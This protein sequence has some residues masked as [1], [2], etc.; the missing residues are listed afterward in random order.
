LPARG[1]SILDTMTTG[2]TDPILLVASIRPPFLR[3]M[4][5][6]VIL[7]P[8]AGSVNSKKKEAL[9]QEIIQIFQKLN[10]EAEVRYVHPPE[11]PLFKVVVTHHPFLPPEDEPSATLVG[12]AELALE[13]L[14]QCG[15]DLLL[16]G[17][18]HKHY[19][20]DVRAHYKR[21]KRSILVVQAGTAVSKRLRGEKNS[22]NRIRVEPPHISIDR[23]TRDGDRFQHNM[24][25]R[26]K[27]TNE[28]WLPEESPN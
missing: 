15:V 28:E 25:L 3:V 26:Y 22:Y 19:M 5:V 7:N 1:F 27:K 10:V 16:A 13:T 12:R 21:V 20:G 14:Q 23:C 17:H 4:K 9:R 6:I 2:R 8:S 24:T 18:F 11:I